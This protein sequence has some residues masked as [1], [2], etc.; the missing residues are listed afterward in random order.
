MLLYRS[1]QNMT[2][3]IIYC[4]SPDYGDLIREYQCYVKKTVYLITLA[5]VQTDLAAKPPITSA[6]P[7]P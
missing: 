1:E 5:C 3:T 4:D 2:P 7:N 6:N